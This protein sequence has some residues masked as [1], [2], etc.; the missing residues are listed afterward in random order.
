MEVARD[1]PTLSL[2]HRLIRAM[3][4]CHL[5]RGYLGCSKCDEDAAWIR[6]EFGQKWIR[7]NGEWMRMEEEDVGEE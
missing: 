5:C 7:W 3:N 1:T 4:R 6:E 2:L